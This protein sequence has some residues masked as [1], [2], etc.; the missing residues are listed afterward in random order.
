MDKIRSEQPA[1]KKWF[2]VQDLLLGQ[3]GVEWRVW[4]LLGAGF[5]K[6]GRASSEKTW[7]WLFL[8][9][10]RYPGA[11]H[12]SPSLVISS[13]AGNGVCRAYGLSRGLTEIV[14]ARGSCRSCCSPCGDQKR[15]GAG[16]SS[17]K[18]LLFLFYLS[19]FSLPNL[20]APWGS[21]DPSCGGQD[22]APAPPLRCSTASLR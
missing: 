2:V 11:G 4:G 9:L 8:W 16:R 6:Q 21:P 19:I 12:A 17:T 14:C 1:K 3:V 22:H 10:L 20:L 15:R 7:G 13:T 18:F 5:C